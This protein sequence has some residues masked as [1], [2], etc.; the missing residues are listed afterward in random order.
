MRDFERTLCRNISAMRCKQ[1]AAKRKKA[2]ERKRTAKKVPAKPKTV[3]SDPA[4]EPSNPPADPSGKPL[5]PAARSEHVDAKPPVPREKPVIAA[6]P[7]PA[8]KPAPQSDTPAKTAT[9]TSPPPA[10]PSSAIVTTPGSV[11]RLRLDTLGAKFETVQENL[12]NGQCRVEH[13]VRLIALDAAGAAIAFPDA[14]VLKC[15]F[16][17]KFAEWLKDTGAPIIRAQA[18]SPVAKMGTGPGYQCRGRNGDVSGK[19]SEHG[20][21]NAVDI[22][23]FTLEDDRVFEVKDAASPASPS[24]ATLKGLRGSAC[25]YFTTVL[26]PGSDSAHEDHFHFDLGKH[27]KTDNYRICE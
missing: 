14:P 23:H 24:Y 10:D 26:G 13:P 3:E 7:E 19:M 1:K 17:V 11:C 5:V 18:N 12:G 9:A 2:A 4:T 20:F 15:E 16:A 21:G 27:G 25:G 22:T 6:A 8:P